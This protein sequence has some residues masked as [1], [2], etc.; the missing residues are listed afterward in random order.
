MYEFA[1]IAV[2]ETANRFSLSLRYK[3]SRQR[4]KRD[5]A[6]NQV[7][8]QPFIQM[9]TADESEFHWR[10]D[11]N[12]ISDDKRRVASVTRNRRC[13]CISAPASLC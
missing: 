13:A 3:Y 4:T 2:R 12:T 11:L 10:D 1:L 9:K 8:K 7:N 6:E 5:V